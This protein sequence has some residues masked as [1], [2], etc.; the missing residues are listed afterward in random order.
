MLL[1][2][3]QTQKTS[4][5]VISDKIPVEPYKWFDPY[6]PCF[7]QPNQ[8]HGFYVLLIEVRR[9]YVLLSGPQLVKCSNVNI[10]Q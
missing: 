1:Y 10:L 3:P 6:R 9:L 7:A 2:D 5:I 4:P 8:A